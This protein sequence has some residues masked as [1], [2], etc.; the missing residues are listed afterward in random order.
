MLNEVELGK[1]EVEIA[2]CIDLYPKELASKIDET[3]EWVY[4]LLNNGVYRCGFST[5]QA[6]YDRASAGVKKGLDRANEVLSENDFLCGGSFTDA[7]LR[8]LPTILRFDGAYSP[9]FRAGGV[10]RRIRDYPNLLAWLQRCWELEGVKETI[11][12]EDAVSSYYR[13]LFPLNPGGLLPTPITL[14]EIGL[15]T[16]CCHN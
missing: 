4:E 14:E 15:K 11:D 2:E 6:A 13:Q 12:L 8:L 1:K 16:E 3:N 5:Q 10:N 9:L 7:D